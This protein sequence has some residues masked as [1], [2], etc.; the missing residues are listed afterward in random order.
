[1]EKHVKIQK[2]IKNEKKNDY[3]LFYAKKLPTEDVILIYW[4][5]SVFFY[6]V[7]LIVS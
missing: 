4:L 6:T 3:A 2:Q 7:I 1:M 5:S